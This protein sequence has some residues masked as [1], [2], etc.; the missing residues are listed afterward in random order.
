MNDW[1]RRVVTVMLS[2]PSTSSLTTFVVLANSWLSVYKKF[3]R[4]R[5]LFQAGPAARPSSRRSTFK[6]VHW[7]DLPRWRGSCLTHAAHFF[8]LGRRDR[9]YRQARPVH[10]AH[11][12][13]LGI[14]LAVRQSHRL[15]HGL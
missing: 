6:S 3:R 4:S 14:G 13:K 10:Q 12:R 2:G 1:L 15:G 5:R 9:L 7:T 11:I 8:P